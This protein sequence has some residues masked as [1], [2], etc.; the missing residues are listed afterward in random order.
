MT[1]PETTRTT[2]R[3]VRLGATAALVAGLM[4]PFAAHAD[5]GRVDDDWAALIGASIVLAH[6]DAPR[7]RDHRYHGYQ[8][9]GHNYRHTKKWR[10]HQKRH[11]Y[12]HQDRRHDRG[13]HRY[14]KRHDLQGDRRGRGG[15]RDHGKRRDGHRRG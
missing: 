13:H 3:S 12:W 1:R 7:Y 4:L 5:H 9:R 8:H 14:E 6:Y 10:K 11:A 2:N 15:D